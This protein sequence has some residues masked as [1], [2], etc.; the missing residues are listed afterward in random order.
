MKIIMAWEVGRNYGHVTKLATLAKAIVERQ[1]KAEII[2][3]LQTPSAV[4]PFTG[5]IKYK[6]LQAP[7]CPPR[8]LADSKSWGASRLFTDDMRPCGYFD[9]DILT[10]LI[11]AW[12]DLYD[13]I[14][15]DI[16]IT[17]A[18][19]TALLAA[20]GHKFKTMMFGG[21]YDVPAKSVPMPPLRYWEKNDPKMLAARE[22][23]ALG[24]TNQALKNAGKKPLK[25]IAEGLKCDAEFLTMFEEL[26][27]YPMRKEIESKPPQYL[28]NFLTQDTGQSMKWNAGATKRIF[29]YIRPASSGFDQT[30]K[31]LATLPKSIDC[32][33]AAPGIAPALKSKIEKPHIRIVDGP[34][35]LSSI[36]KKC[37]LGICHA[38]NGISCAFALNGVPQLL[39]PAHIEQFMFAKAVGRNKLGRGVVGNFGPEKIAEVM[40][41][42]LDDPQYLNASKAF[43]KKYK[44]FKPENIADEIA[45]DVLKLIKP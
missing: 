44:G 3:A 37:D 7:Y 6:L 29:A 40:K 28:G 8:P 17:E 32:I 45:R 2:F 5:D 14:K 21:S 18:A 19:P 25:N 30:L 22:A 10:G 4:I 24:I 38:S 33:I 42:L 16:L 36:L 13:I 31:V 12:S 35:K 9:P 20:R 34:V 27:H 39:L 23:E 43:A 15:P 26:D 1:K 11:R 41:I